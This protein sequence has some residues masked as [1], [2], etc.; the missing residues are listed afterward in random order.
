VSPIVTAILA[1]A[2]AAAVAAV[3]IGLGR[4]AGARREAG[5]GRPWWAA[6]AV[7]LAYLAGHFVAARPAVPPADVTDRIPWLA[8][9]ATALALA[10]SAGRWMRATGW[11]LLA[12]LAVGLVLGPVIGAGDF[13]REVVVWL[14]ASIAVAVL[15]WADLAVLS[16]RPDRSDL[17]RALLITC[18]G[19]A[20]ALPLSGFGMGGPLSAALAAALA[21]AWLAARGEVPAGYAPVAATVLTALVLEGFVYAVLPAASAV[22]LAAAPAATWLTRLGPV[23]RLGPWASAA[24]GGAAVLVPVAVAVGLAAAAVESSPF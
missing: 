15:S 14:A 9:A 13:S 1:V 4:L 7:G 12:A 5:R 24:V 10:E 8:L 20:A 11:T 6:S 2:A 23:R 18:G 19:A 22:L 16:A 17:L 3:V 21:A